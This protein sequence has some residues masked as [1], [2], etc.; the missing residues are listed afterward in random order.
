MIDPFVP[1]LRET[2]ELYS[3]LPASTLYEMAR[4]RGYP[5]QPSHFRH[6]IARSL[7]RRRADLT[8]S[9]VSPT[10]LAASAARSNDVIE[11]TSEGNRGQLH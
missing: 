10:R 6:C 11:I 2:L 5:G 4:Q 8:L 3:R 7:L 1:W 9:S